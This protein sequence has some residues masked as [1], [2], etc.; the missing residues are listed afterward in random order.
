[1]KDIKGPKVEK[2]LDTL[3][4]EERLLKIRIT[5]QRSVNRL[6]VFVDKIDIKRA[7]VNGVPLS[8]NYLDNRRNNRLIT[9]YISDND[10]TSLL[11][12][13]PRDSPVTLNL[14]EASNDLLKNPLFSVPERPLNSIPMPFVLNDAIMT[15]QTVTF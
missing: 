3:I 8:K 11:L 4:N 9:H 10:T 1:M 2:L 13:I 12:V 15:T 6:D 7:S 14:Y 5:P